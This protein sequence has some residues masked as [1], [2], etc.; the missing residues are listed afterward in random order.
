[1][2]SRTPVGVDGGVVFTGIVEATGS[3]R[4]IRESGGD[5]LL[6]ITCPAINFSRVALGD[7][8]AVSGVCLTVVETGADWFS[9]DV[10]RETLACTTLGSWKPGEPVNLEQ[11]L[12]PQGRLG[13][14]IV[15]GHVDGVG[16]VL[17]RRPDGRSER[18]EI[19]VP[20]ELARYI[21]HKGSV[22][23]DGV[24]LTVNEVGA[25]HFSVNIIPHTAG[26]TTL[27]YYRPGRRVNIE[28]DVLSRYL[29]RLLEQGRAPAEGLTLDKLAAS[30]FTRS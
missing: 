16:E 26:R 27:Q 28:V 14:H 21:A 3:V 1:V 4:S 17:A 20:Q 15:S 2:L 25:D 10:S 12:T 19:R 8:I 7:S 23:M 9:A 13:G 11:A 30:G 24:S 5:W 18:I 6:T 29:E 22:C